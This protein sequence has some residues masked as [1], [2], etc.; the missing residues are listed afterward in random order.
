[1]AEPAYRFA[2]TVVAGFL[3]GIVTV[4]VLAVRIKR[5]SVPS[6]CSVWIWLLRFAVHCCHYSFP[7]E[8]PKKTAESV[9]TKKQNTAEA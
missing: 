2:L 1:M 8:Y 3:R 6:V 9:K 5:R 7:G 4:N